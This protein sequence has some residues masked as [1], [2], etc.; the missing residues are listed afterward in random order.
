MY[1]LQ[2]GSGSAAVAVHH[3]LVTKHQARRG[4]HCGNQCKPEGGAGVMLQGLGLW[5]ILVTIQQGRVL[6]GQQS[7][8][9]DGS[10]ENR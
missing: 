1:I 7:D 6:T 8:P 9:W 3:T 4:C 10:C 5:H 2:R